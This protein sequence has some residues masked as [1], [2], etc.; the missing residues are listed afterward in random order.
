MEHVQQLLN[1]YGLVLNDFAPNNEMLALMPSTLRSSISFANV[2]INREEVVLIDTAAELNEDHLIQLIQLLKNVPLPIIFL[3]DSFSIDTQ[4]LLTKN[5][6]GFISQMGFYLP[7]LKPVKITKPTMQLISLSKNQQIIILALIYWK[8]LHDDDSNTFH[9]KVRQLADYLNI[10]A[11]TISRALRTF[12]DAGW[13][14]TSGYTRNHSFAIPA[15]YDLNSWMNDILRLLPSPVQKTLYIPVNELD[16]ITNRKLA[17]LT[18]LSKFTLIAPTTLVSWAIPSNQLTDDL[19]K[20]DIPEFN[21]RLAPKNNVAIE[22]WKY[23]SQ[24]FNRLIPKNYQLAVDPVS[25]FLSLR[26]SH[27]K[28][29]TEQ[30][31]KLLE[32]LVNQH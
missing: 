7:S 6:F 8:L 28:E 27:T 32:N 21:A 9:I 20:V 19:K 10:T 29:V 25:L 4:I 31:N 1:Q 5:Q 13:L 22:I 15:G 18:A 16:N 23:D 2:T 14:S 12:V 11:M 24:V 17:N 3:A 26:N 30:L